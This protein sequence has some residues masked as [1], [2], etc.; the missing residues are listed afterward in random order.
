M[1]LL[2]ITTGTFQSK[3]H[4]YELLRHPGAENLS[5]LFKLRYDKLTQNYAYPTSNGNC[6]HLSFG[7][8]QKDYESVCEIQQ[9]N[10]A[11][12]QNSRFDKIKRLKRERK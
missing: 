6:I 4:D 1:V 11:S 9:I 5:Q 2:K 8:V 10:S 7:T 3:L 12:E